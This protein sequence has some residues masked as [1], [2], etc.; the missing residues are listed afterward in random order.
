MASVFLYVTRRRVGVWDEAAA[1]ARLVRVGCADDDLALDLDDALR[2]VGGLA[3]ADADGV[4]LCDVLGDGEELRHRLERFSGVV[5]VESGDD[6]AHAALRERV[7]HI[8]QFVVEELTLVNADDL[9][10][11]LDLREYLGSR[12]R[13]SRLVSHL[14]VRDDV[15]ARVAHVN[16][17]LEDLHF[18]ARNLRA[19]K[20]SYE[21]FRLA[22]KHR[23]GDHLYPTRRAVPDSREVLVVPLCHESFHS[24]N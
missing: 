12:A 24:S 8:D 18:E 23:T 3:A 4:R 5:L 15:I 14:G 6:D 10:V 13:D 21:F 7:R 11:R 16:F 17:G 19:P 2:V 1:A 22:R 9:R 20:A